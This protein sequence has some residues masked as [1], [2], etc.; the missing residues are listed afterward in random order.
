MGEVFSKI[1]YANHF[2]QEVSN[3]D[4]WQVAVKIKHL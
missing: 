1:D 2:L 4:L 3:P